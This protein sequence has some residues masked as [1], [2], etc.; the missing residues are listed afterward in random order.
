MNT[1][2]SFR[3]TELVKELCSMGHNV[4]LVTHHSP[5]IHDDIAKEYGFEIINLEGKVKVSTKGKNVVIKGIQWIVNRLFDYPNI[6]LLSAVDKAIRNLKGYDVLL[7]VAAPHSIHWGVTNALKHNN[8]LART[9][10]ADCGDP[11]MGN[12]VGRKKMFYFKYLEKWFCR[13]ADYILVPIAEA[14]VGY[15]EEFRN[16]ITVV[17]QGFNFAET[18]ALLKKY[19][20]NKEVTFAFTGNFIVNQRDPRPLLDYLCGVDIPFKFIVYTKNDELL[21]KYKNTLNNKLEVSPYIPRTELI[22]ILSKMDFLVNLEN[23][24][25]VQRPSKLVDYSLVARPV[26]S[27]DSTNMDYQKIDQFL[28]GDYSQQ[29]HIRNVEQ[30]DIRNIC[31]TI[32]ALADHNA[33]K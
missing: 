14:V 21:H 7:S 15:Y 22:P 27:L 29:L 28:A 4:I 20:P 5:E 32:L 31:D 33:T 17:P 24:T 13:R 19:E 6:L 1:P 11:Y 12:A 2:R 30:Y 26:L 16:K 18:K 10:I 9:W 25:S 8:E 3:T 23:G